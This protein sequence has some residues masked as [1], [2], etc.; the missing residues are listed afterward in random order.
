MFYRGSDV[1]DLERVGFVHN[2]RGVVGRRLAVPYVTLV[3]GNSAQGHLYGTTLTQSEKQELLEY[4]R[5][6]QF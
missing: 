5:I 3:P 6:G 4:L 1:L 2:S